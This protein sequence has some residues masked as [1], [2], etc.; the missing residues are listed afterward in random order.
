MNELGL[1]NLAALADPWGKANEVGQ[2]WGVCGRGLCCA[3]ALTP[4][5]PERQEMRACCQRLDSPVGM[6][7]ARHL[8]DCVSRPR[9]GRRGSAPSPLSPR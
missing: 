7:S 3:P 5:R 1:I 9:G 2:T 6:A 8:L 4:A